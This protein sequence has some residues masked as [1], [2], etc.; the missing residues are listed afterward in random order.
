MEALRDRLLFGLGSPE[1]VIPVEREER[2]M[3]KHTMQWRKPL[4]V[5]EIGQMADTPEV[6]AREGRP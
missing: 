3:L 4:S 1:P 6:R 5:S 2:V